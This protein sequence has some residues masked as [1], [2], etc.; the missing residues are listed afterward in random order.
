[1]F[2]FCVDQEVVGNVFILREF[3]LGENKQLK[4][5][6]LSYEQMGDSVK[7]RE[8]INYVYK[9]R[10]Y[11]AEASFVVSSFFQEEIMEEFVLFIICYIV[12][13]I[14]YELYIVK[15]AKKSKDDN[16]KSK[17]KAKEPVEILYLK[18]KYDLDM[19]K[20]DYNQLLQIVALV[21]S[22]DISVIV[23]VMSLIPNFFVK[24]IVGFVLIFLM[25]YIS[26]YFVYLFYKKKGMVKHGKH[27][28]D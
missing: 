23:S 17:K 12:V 7:N 26:Y 11:H 21:S 27:K 20:V 8:S 10:W 28:K 15:R 4:L 18:S 1:M 6:N 3:M 9:L 24:L 16:T 22:F 13:L 2:I 25:V 19:K 5:L 14:F